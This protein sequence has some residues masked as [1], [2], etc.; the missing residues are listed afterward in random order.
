MSLDVE[1]LRGGSD[2]LFL[3]LSKVCRR[4]MAEIYSYASILELDAALSAAG[5]GSVRCRV[6]VDCVC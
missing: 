6:E 2:K 4:W 3:P 5:R 1:G